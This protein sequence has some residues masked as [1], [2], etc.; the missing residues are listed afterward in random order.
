MLPLGFK[1]LKECAPEKYE[2]MPS[3]RAVHLT[4][5]CYRLLEFNDT[6]I[7]AYVL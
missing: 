1:S 5:I 7:N 3:I 4:V 6:A 2:S